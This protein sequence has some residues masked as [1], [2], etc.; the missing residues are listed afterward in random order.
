MNIKAIIIKIIISNTKDIINDFINTI[1]INKN[2]K[3]N[4]LLKILNKAYD[5]NKLKNYQLKYNIFVKKHYTL[6]HNTYP[7]LSRGLIIR[8]CG[9][10]L[11]K[12]I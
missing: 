4:K 12:I 2:Y 5:K 9:E 3:I 8:Q 7:F 1:D 6:L 10:L 11:K